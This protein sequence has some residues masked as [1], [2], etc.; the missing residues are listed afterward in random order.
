GRPVTDGPRLRV[1]VAGQGAMRDAQFLR[2][3]LVRGMGAKKADLGLYPQPMRGEGFR[4]VTVALPPHLVLKNL[5]G[6]LSKLAGDEKARANNLASYDVVVAYD[7]D[8]EKLG[9]PALLALTRWLEAGGGLVVVAGPLNTPRLAG[10]AG[11]KDEAKA[12]RNLLPVVL[13][14][15]VDEK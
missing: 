8:L 7:L 14:K 2:A 12:A 9:K 4:P 6:T 11:K 13:D 3:G 15:S 1:L 5:P 10:P